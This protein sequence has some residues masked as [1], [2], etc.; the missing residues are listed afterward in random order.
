MGPT[1]LSRA[2]TVGVNWPGH[3]PGLGHFSSSPLGQ[4][5]L[6]EAAEAAH[7]VCVPLSLPPSRSAHRWA[8]LCCALQCPLFLRGL[9]LTE[10]RAPPHPLC[11]SLQPLCPE[12]RGKSPSAVLC[13][14]PAIR[15][16]GAPMALT[17]PARGYRQ[18][19]LGREDLG[20]AVR[21]W[22]RTPADR[23]QSPCPP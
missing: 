3:R 17:A 5:V 19:P 2:P 11:L 21:T 12:N 7:L 16:G 13:H 22:S 18:G 6:P 23:A 14:V 8:G 10:D 1:S 20:R 4:K 9:R 15:R